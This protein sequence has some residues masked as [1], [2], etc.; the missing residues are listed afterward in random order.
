M[1]LH[2]VG[3][4]VN[5]IDAQRARYCKYFGLQPLSDVVTDLTQ[6]VNVQFLGVDGADTSV[7]LIEPLPGDSPA[8]Q[9]LEK[10]G[11]LNHL[12]F[13]VDDIE[14]TVETAIADGAICVRTPVAATAFDGRR[15]AFVFFR[16]IGL[17]EYVEA[18]AA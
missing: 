17:I 18:P 8:R 2:H 12:C 14:G 10:G 1:R 9:A 15:I 5:S 16:G 7:E 11:T 6:H 13:E 3:V 4:V